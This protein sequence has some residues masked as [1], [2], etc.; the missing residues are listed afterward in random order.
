[1]FIIYLFI[2][3]IL[4]SYNEIL[5]PTENTCVGAQKYISKT[6]NNKTLNKSK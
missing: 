2:Y 3:F 4:I 1:M 5:G 6:D